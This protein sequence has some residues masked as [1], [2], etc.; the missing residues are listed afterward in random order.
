MSLQPYGLW[1]FCLQLG[2]GVLLAHVK[3]PNG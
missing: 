2:A 3:G 1:P